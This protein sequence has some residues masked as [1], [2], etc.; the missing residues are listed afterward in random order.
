[1]P[2][3][4]ERVIPS[5]VWY[6]KLLFTSLYVKPVTKIS[7]DNKSPSTTSNLPLYGSL[8]YNKTLP[9]EPLKILSDNTNEPA[10]LA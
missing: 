6:T 5:A 10:L 1:M 9:S 8:E 4:I 2:K 7:P 3:Y